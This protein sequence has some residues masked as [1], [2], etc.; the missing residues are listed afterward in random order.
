MTESG[1]TTEQITVY[2]G[3]GTRGLLP[4]GT[5]IDQCVGKVVSDRAFLSTSTSKNYA[6]DGEMNWKITVPKGRRALA[7]DNIVDDPEVPFEYEVV[8]PPNTKL[9][10]D[11]VRTEVRTITDRVVYEVEATVIE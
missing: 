8:L 10:I 9:R 7:I 11:R 4:T 6:F 3:T 2:R 1:R 5:T